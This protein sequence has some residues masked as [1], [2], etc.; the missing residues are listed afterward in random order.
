[1][2]AFGRMQKDIKPPLRST[3]I[4][5]VAIAITATLPGISLADEGGVG[6]WYPG[7]YGSLAAELQAQRDGLLRHT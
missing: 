5:V 1:M 2:V 7:T 4:A 6:F 3:A